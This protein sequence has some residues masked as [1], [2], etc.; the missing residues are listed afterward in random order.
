MTFQQSAASFTASTTK[1]SVTIAACT[2]VVTGEGRQRLG[3]IS[4][5]CGYRVYNSCSACCWLGYLGVIPLNLYAWDVGR[6]ECQYLTN[7]W[8]A[9][10]KVANNQ[11]QVVGLFVK[12]APDF[13]DLCEEPC[14]VTATFPFLLYFISIKNLYNVTVLPLCFHWQMSVITWKRCYIFSR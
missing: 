8:T 7:L 10:W 2:D 12:E 5:F 13:Q 1:D 4:L 11:I 6:K 3:C 14:S 9:N